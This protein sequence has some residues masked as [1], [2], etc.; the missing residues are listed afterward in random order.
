M[1]KVLSIVIVV[2]VL[3]FMLVLVSCTGGDQTTTTQTTTTTTINQ[4]TTV[5]PPVD[6]HEHSYSATVT[7]PT[8][9]QDGYT[10]YTC[11]CG[12]TNWG[13][14]VDA[15]GHSESEWIIDLEPTRYETGS[16]HKDCSVCGQI[17]ATEIIPLLDYSVGLEYKL[18][19][20]GESY[21]VIGIGTCTDNDVIIPTNFNGKPVTDIAANAFKGCTQLTDIFVPDTIITIG[22]ASFSVC[23]NLKHM[24]L[25]FVGLSASATSSASLFGTIFGTIKYKESLATYQYSNPQSSGITFYVP[26]SLESVTITGGNICFGAFANCKNIKEIV[27]PETASSIGGLAFYECNSLKSIEIPNSV[28]SIG[29]EAFWGCDSLTS[30]TIPEN[31]KSI[32]N[33]A[34]SMCESLTE[35][36]YNAIEIIEVG[37]TNSIDSQNLIFQAAGKKGKGITLTIGKNVK[38]IP[39]YLFDPYYNP[40]TQ[41]PNIV[42]VV[43]EEGSVCSNIGDYAFA[44]CRSLK[45]ILI[46]NG[47]KHIGEGAL[48]GCYSLNAIVIPDSVT[49]I[50]SWV[51]SGCGIKSATIGNSLTSISDYAFYSCD[52]LENIVIPDG[53]TN[54]GKFAFGFCLSLKN[55]TIGSRVNSIHDYAFNYTNALININVSTN[56]D[57]YKSIDGDLYSKDGKTLVKYA[58]GKTD[59]MFKIPEGVTTIGNNAFYSSVS[60]EIVEIPNSVIFIGNEAF[61]NCNALNFL[62]FE[63]PY[64]WYAVLNGDPNTE[65][66]IELT[67]SFNNVDL[68]QGYS[69]DWYWYKK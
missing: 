24:T 23:Y 41:H 43:F 16:K 31:V 3:T 44:S 46:P 36:Y 65:V 39:A 35:I 37:K 32:G 64:A 11:K 53:V 18:N 28:L 49:F 45:S 38:S 42:S 14:Y 57:I 4:E 25:P 17:I 20:D 60:L 21:S 55:I 34:F 52:L 12:D 62:I 13:D 5:D 68:F 22:T 67:N 30:L 8:C 6:E 50:G 59:S 56:N 61:H 58:T 27:L 63:D 54:I 40:V 33:G 48:S 47:V 29:S 7:E 2:F 15:T 69:Y 66:E 19:S 9:T 26:S 51:F 10:T 1:K